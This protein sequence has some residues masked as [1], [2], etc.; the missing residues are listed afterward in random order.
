MSMTRRSRAMSVR[1]STSAARSAS[2]GAMSTGLAYPSPSVLDPL[3]PLPAGGFGQP[4]GEDL[5]G[6]GSI[7]H[8]GPLVLAR[9]GDARGDVGDA[10]CGVRHVHVLPTGTAGSVRLDPEVLGIDLDLRV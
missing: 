7:L 10:N 9:R 6:H 2:A 4:R 1:R 3:L 5:H 8:L